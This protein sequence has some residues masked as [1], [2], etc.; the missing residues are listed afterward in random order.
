MRFSRSLSQNWRD[1]AEYSLE[2]A[3]L[4]LA[5]EWLDFLEILLDFAGAWLDKQKLDTI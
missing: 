1:L 4:D 3:G 5:E 2:E